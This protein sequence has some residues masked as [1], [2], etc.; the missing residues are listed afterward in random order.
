MMIDGD[1]KI[2][3]TGRGAFANINHD[4]FIWRFTPNGVLDS[5]FGLDDPSNSDPSVKLG[6][7]VFDDPGS[8]GGSGGVGNDVGHD[9]TIDSSNRIY[10][11]GESTFDDTSREMVIWRYSTN[12]EIDLSFGDDDPSNSDPAI[13]LG[14][15]VN[16]GTA[17]GTLNDSCLAI[18]IDSVGRVLA[19]G[20]SEN[21]GG[22]L[23]WDMVLWRFIQD[24]VL[25]TTFGDDDPSNI[26]PLVKLGFA[27]RDGDA[28]GIYDDRGFV[29]WPSFLIHP[30]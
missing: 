25:D 5:T 3:V 8:S 23:F 9:I 7:A 21:G 27:I 28:G 19:T 13:K 29:T 17:G 26:D 22:A 18:K 6:Y 10:V 12:G 11:C 1:G 30:S 14:F 15:L 2:L 24:G 4:M 20:Y 16:D